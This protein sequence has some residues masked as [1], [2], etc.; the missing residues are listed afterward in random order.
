M[1]DGD[2]G[3]RQKQVRVLPRVIIST[4]TST[5]MGHGQFYHPIPAYSHTDMLY[6]RTRAYIYISYDMQWTLT[7]YTG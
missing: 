2:E 5:T 7:N 1:F 3:E 6:S 4:C